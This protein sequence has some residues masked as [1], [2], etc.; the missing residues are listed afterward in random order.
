ML[1]YCPTLRKRLGRLLGEIYQRTHE[2]IGEIII[3][4]KWPYR[5]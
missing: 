1:R 5:C 2:K 4:A 3:V